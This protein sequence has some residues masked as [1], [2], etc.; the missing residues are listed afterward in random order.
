M[1]INKASLIVFLM[2]L[3]FP[4]LSL[5]LAEIFGGTKLGNYTWPVVGFIDLFVVLSW[6]ASRM[7]MRAENLK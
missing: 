7:A 3:L 4:T 5:G 1:R 2:L 6:F